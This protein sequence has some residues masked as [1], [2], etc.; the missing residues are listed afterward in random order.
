M[1]WPGVPAGQTPKRVRS[2]LVIQR[3]GFGSLSGDNE[4]RV[5][6]SQW[7]LDL[8]WNGLM[9][10]RGDLGPVYGQQWRNFGGVVRSQNWSSSQD[11]PDKH[12]A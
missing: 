4:Y 12:A 1:I 3:T 11:H 5:F 8:G 9:R 6:E 10:N 2:N 7:R